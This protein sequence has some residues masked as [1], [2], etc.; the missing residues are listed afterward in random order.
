MM[1]SKLLIAAASLVVL[2]GCATPVL[3]QRVPVSSDPPGATARDDSG[4]SCLTPCALDLD[5]NRDHIV[6]VMLEGYHPQ[7]I[8]VRRQYRTADVLLSALNSGLNSARVSNN[9]S[10]ALQSGLNNKAAQEASGAAYTLEPS[11]ISVRLQ[12]RGGAAG[13]VTPDIAR[14]ALE[15]T[16]DG[17]ALM[18]RNDQQML[19]NALENATPGEP[20]AWTNPDTGARYAVVTDVVGLQD[21]QVLRPFT[22]SVSHNRDFSSRRYQAMRVGRGEW[23]ILPEASGQNSAPPPPASQIPPVST[24][25]VSTPTPGARSLPALPLGETVRVGASQTWSNERTKSHTEVSRPAPGEQ[26]S[27]TR[28]TTRG[29]STSV[30]VDVSAGGI[31]E[32]LNAL[33][34]FR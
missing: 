19:E 6:S 24:G 27:T 16:L 9:P 22:L 25:H 33:G 15:Q 4:A 3:Q 34:V 2:A 32:T 7:D 29:T 30:G 10:W 26:V 12:P 28:S 23:Q 21:G 31:I 11:T 18:D 5:R 17:L 13:P 14:L 1:S 20:T 8:A